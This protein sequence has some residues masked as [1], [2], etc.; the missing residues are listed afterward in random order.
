M[1]LL[2]YCT[3]C[4]VCMCLVF[5]FS[6]SKSFFDSQSCKIFWNQISPWRE[7]VESPH[8]PPLHCLFRSGKNTHV[9]GGGGS[10]M[11]PL[12]SFANSLHFFKHPLIHAYSSP[13]LIT[14][15]PTSEV[16]GG[17]GRR[18]SVQPLK[19]AERNLGR[20][21]GSDSLTPTE[22]CL[23]CGESAAVFD[24]FEIQNKMENY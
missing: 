6:L 8:P 12:S 1:L 17:R 20:G 19:D 24:G 23:I 15:Q 7:F 5:L 4:R 22:R 13:H 11:R 9:R 14:I 10:S 21:G 3:S 16:V 2:L 18:P